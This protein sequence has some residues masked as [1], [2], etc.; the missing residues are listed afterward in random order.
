LTAGTVT[1]KVPAPTE[2]G[3]LDVEA[4]IKD[5]AGN[6]SAPVTDTVTKDTTVPAAPVVEINDDGTSVTVTGEEGATVTVT[7]PTGT[8]EGIIV[9]GS[10]TAALTPALSNGEEVSAVQ[11]DAAGN[12]SLPGK[13]NATDSTAPAAPVVD[14]NDDGTSVT[15]TGE[16]GATVTITTPTGTIEGI[17][18]DGTFTAAL[19]PALSNSEEVS[20][21]QTDAAGNPSLPGKDNATDSTAPAAP[22]VD[23]NDDGSSVTVTGE[24]GATVTITTPTGTIEGI[25]VDGTFTAALTPA[26]SNS[27]EVSA[28]QT[29]AAGNPSL[30]GKDNATDS[31]A[32]AA[33][34]VDINDDGTSVTVTG[35]EGA[36]V[37]ITTPTGTIEGIIVDGSFTA[38][39]DPALSNGEEVSAVQT[40]AAGNPSLPGKDN[41]TDSTAPA[42]PAIDAFDG[43]TVTGT[44]EP[45]STVNILDENDA[46]IGTATADAVTGAYEVTLTTPLA[47]GEAITA[48]ATDAANNTSAE[49][50]PSTAPDT[51]AP[52]APAIDAFDGT[53]VTGTAEPGSTVNILDENDAIIGTATAD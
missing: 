41:A 40:D 3:K 48:T 15:V 42:A 52:A 18:V 50:A 6:T 23:I 46:I 19:T 10:F 7:T 8:I 36:T 5:P 29:D 39:L 28:V 24:E 44:A 21:V 38:T 9:D 16:E 49:S 32:P 14:I 33:P 45:G 22:V 30:P 34:V 27:E 51:T 43:T 17:I 25:I 47:N 13:D 20:A 37:T 12:P 4:T 35:E 26:L 11:T 1:V 31:T 53:T 2:G